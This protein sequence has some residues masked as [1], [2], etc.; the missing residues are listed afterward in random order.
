VRYGESRKSL[1]EGRVQG[2]Y[3]FETM[4]LIFK[5]VVEVLKH[6]FLCLKDVWEGSGCVCSS[7]VL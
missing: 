2:W 1:L 6:S 7:W 3:L 4:I 5:I